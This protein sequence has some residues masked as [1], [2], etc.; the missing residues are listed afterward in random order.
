[1]Q[2][3]WRLKN[4]KYWE[5]TEDHLKYKY[6]RP[7]TVFWGVCLELVGIIVFAMEQS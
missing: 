3:F 7:Q 4:G 1:M 5:N 2:Y 6:L